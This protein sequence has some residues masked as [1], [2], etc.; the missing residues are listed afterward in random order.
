MNE[1]VMAVAG[2]MVGVWTTAVLIV[3]S[4]MTARAEHRTETTVRPGADSHENVVHITIVDVAP[5]G[6]TNVPSLPTLVVRARQESSVIFD[7]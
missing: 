1:R 5:N 4:S 3:G 6:K 7:D 2:L